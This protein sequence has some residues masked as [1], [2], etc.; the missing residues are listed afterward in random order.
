[1]DCCR[2]D[3]DHIRFGPTEED[4]LRVEEERSKFV[5]RLVEA[6]RKQR[7]EDD[8]EPVSA[9][10]HDYRC[11]FVPDLG[12][13]CPRS[14]SQEE[15]SMPTLRC[16][17]RVQSVAH[18]KNEDGTTSQE[19]VKLSAVYGADGTDNAQWSKWT[20]SAQF[21]ITINNPDAF[22]KLSQGHEFYVD[23]TPAE[24]E[25]KSAAA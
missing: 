1:M 12:W 18:Y 13:Q 4:Y 17:M 11:R 24:A 2:G 9:H 19:E 6:I 3:I 21:S 15:E 16:K 25:V 5:S 7:E 22:N 10:R 23:F 14:I 20:P 8:L